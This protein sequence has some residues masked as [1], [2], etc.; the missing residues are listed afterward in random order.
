MKILGIIPSRW[1]SSRFPGKPLIKIGSKSMIERVYKQTAKALDYVVVATDDQRISEAVE[2][3]GGRF[4]MTSVK[5]QSGTD[6]SAEALDIVE[7]ETGEKFDVV[8]N[9]QGD[10]PFIQPEQIKDISAAFEDAT[11]EIATLIKK[12][13]KQEILF[14]SSRPKVIKNVRDEA[15]YF[16]RSTIPFIQNTDKKDWCDKFTYFEHLGLYAYRAEVLRKITQLAASSL[17]LAESLEQN[18]WLENGFKIKVFESEQENISINTPEDLE[19]LL[20]Q[21]FVD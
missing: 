5:H 19:R 9:I 21:G 11:T 16:S 7:K 4:A 1:A 2:N 13:T 10:E 8:I 18:R 3:F 15:I 6:R 20:K 17:E 14:D 12:I